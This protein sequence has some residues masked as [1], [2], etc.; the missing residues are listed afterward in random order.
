[1]LKK[2]RNLGVQLYRVSRSRMEYPWKIPVE[3]LKT[4]LNITEWVSLLK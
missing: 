4:L 2:I 1:M 3:V